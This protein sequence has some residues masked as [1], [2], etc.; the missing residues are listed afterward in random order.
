[1]YEQR[2][3]LWVNFGNVKYCYCYG[4]NS[5]DMMDRGDIL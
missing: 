5:E 1:M 2:S 4:V 3:K